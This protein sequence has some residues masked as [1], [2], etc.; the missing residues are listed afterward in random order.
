MK[1]LFTDPDHT[2][3][4]MR[5]LVAGMAI[6]WRRIKAGWYVAEIVPDEL[7]IHI[8]K[9]ESFGWDSFSSDSRSEYSRA[10]MIG[11]C[12]ATLNTAQSFASEWARRA[13][14]VR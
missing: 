14:T 10:R 11:S 1:P 8:K 9:D 12:D 13:K 4:N 2:P 7:Y 6:A 5:H 3:P